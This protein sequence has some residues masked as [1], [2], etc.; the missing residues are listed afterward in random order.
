MRSGIKAQH[1]KMASTH[2]QPL[3]NLDTPPKTKPHCKILFFTI[4]IFALVISA[5]LLLPKLTIRSTDNYLSSPSYMCRGALNTKAC[6][7]FVSEV[8]SDGVTPPDATLLLQKFLIEQAHHMNRAILQTKKVKNQRNEQNEQGPLA[9]C[10]ELFDLSI[11]LVF[12]SIKALGNQGSTS[13]ANAQAWLSGVLTNHV[14]CFDGLNSFGRKSIGANLEDLIS[15]ASASLAMLAAVSE[16]D[17]EMSRPL[18]GNLP[19]WITPADRKLLQSTAN[20]IKADLV[21]AKDGSG[22]YKTVADAIAA[23][24]DK[25]KKRYVIYA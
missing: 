17:K 13:H 8:V 15:R 25:S 9:D 18:R 20:A 21:V 10:L 14:T 6:Q 4:S 7:E 22:N 3:L 5:A 19:S 2:Q 23:A 24:P 16:P 11:D 12:D 1:S